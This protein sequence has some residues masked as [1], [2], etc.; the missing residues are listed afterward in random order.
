MSIKCGV[1]IIFVGL[2]NTSAIQA[3]LQNTLLD[4]MH[5]HRDL[6]T[7]AARNVVA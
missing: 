7:Y 2:R 5:H 6:S 1:F 3:N 4:Q